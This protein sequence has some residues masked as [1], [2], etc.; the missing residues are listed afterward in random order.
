MK[1][2]GA[3]ANSKFFD[4]EGFAFIPARIWGGGLAPLSS[5]FR[6]H[7]SLVGPG[8][9]ACI[10]DSFFTPCP[11]PIINR[12]Y[13]KTAWLQTLATLVNFHPGIDI[14]PP[15]QLIERIVNYKTF[16]HG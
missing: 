4:G 11:P 12:G 3:E 14:I 15:L 10:L 13:F 9:K 8:I 7:C 1:I 16:H 6:R 2:E 5:W